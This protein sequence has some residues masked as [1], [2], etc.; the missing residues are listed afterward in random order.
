MTAFLFCI[1]GIMCNVGSSLYP[2]SRPHTAFQRLLLLYTVQNCW[3]FSRSPLAECFC[4]Q[5]VF[6]CLLGLTDTQV[7]HST[8]V[9]CLMEPPSFSYRLCSSTWVCFHLL[10]FWLHTSKKKHCSDTCV[11][12]CL[13]SVTVGAFRQWNWDTVNNLSTQHQIQLCIWERGEC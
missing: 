9:L 1:K 7:S 12:V 10:L 8:T 5:F 3:S 2:A 11:C 6:A 4:V 13:M